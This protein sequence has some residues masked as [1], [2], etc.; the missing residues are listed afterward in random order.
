MGSGDFSRPDDGRLKP[1]LPYTNASRVFQRIPMITMDRLRERLAAANA[2]REINEALGLNLSPEA[3]AKEV[4]TKPEND[5]IVWQAFVDGSIKSKPLRDKLHRHPFPD[6]PL[7]WSYSGDSL[8]YHVGGG[9]ASAI[10]ITSKAENRQ[11]PFESAS[12]V[13]D[14]GCGISRILR[15]LI[16]FCSGPQYYASEVVPDF[17]RWGQHAFPEA[18]YLPQQNRPPL[19]MQEGSLEIIYAYSIFTHFEEKLHRLWLSELHRLLQPD[20]LLILTVHGETILRRC[21]G[22]EH[23]RKELCVVGRNYDDLLRKFYRDGYVFY[24]CYEPKHLAK[25]GIDARKYG[26]AYISQDYINK[27][28]SNQFQLLEYDKGGDGN[29]QDYVIL[30]RR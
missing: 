30:K 10:R 6:G 17:I 1:P 29:W 16:E 21:Q 15:Y 5:W 28:W 8:E 19:A 11:H 3:L 9:L 14:F 22:E 12:K 20:G 18:T 13:L 23:V 27:N 24:K 7:L 2:W 4:L 25:G 26:I